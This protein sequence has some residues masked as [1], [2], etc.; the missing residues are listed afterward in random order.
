MAY[1]AEWSVFIDGDGLDPT[2][3]A[4]RAREW[5]KDPSHNTWRIVDLSKNTS[6]VVD[7]SPTTGPRVIRPRK[8]KTE[9]RPVIEV[10]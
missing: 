7:I 4:R 6:T 10:K 3:V 9:A 8:P 2:E 1:Y 5:S